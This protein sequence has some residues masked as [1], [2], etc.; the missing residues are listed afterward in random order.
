MNFLDIYQKTIILKIIK[1]N[2]KTNRRNTFK[3]KDQIKN[4]DTNL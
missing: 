1:G 4:I 3:K 2:K